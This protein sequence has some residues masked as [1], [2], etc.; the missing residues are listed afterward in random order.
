[1]SPSSS[2]FSGDLTGTAVDSGAR[3]EIEILRQQMEDLQLRLGTVE[4]ELSQLQRA[5]M[6]PM[7]NADPNAL[8]ESLNGNQILDVYAQVVQIAGRRKINDGISV[9][10]SSTL[11]AMFGPPREDL[12]DDCQSLTNPR[13]KDLLVL[14][15]VGPIRVNLLRPAV[16]SLTRVFERV[17]R[18]DVE[19][20][21]RITSAGGLCVRRIRGSET[22]VSTHAYG[23]ALDLNI[24]G[25]L[26]TLGDGKTQLGLTILSDFFQEEGWFWGAAFGRE[27]S[28]HFEVSQEMLSRWRSAGEI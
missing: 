19:L 7:V 6:A 18:M 9:A 15:D 4:E 17:K 3:I 11:L 23:L 10:G 26:D 25:V 24:D 20:Y 21:S 28:M 14:A 2:D 16:E 13:V 12:S 1:M 5:P 22:A 27:D 8:L